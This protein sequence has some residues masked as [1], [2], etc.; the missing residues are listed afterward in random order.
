MSDPTDFGGE[1]VCLEHAIRGAFQTYRG[2]RF[3]AGVEALVEQLL[4]REPIHY[5]LP[6]E[7]EGIT[8]RFKVGEH[9]G[10]IT[11]STY[12]ANYP[13]AFLRGR[14]GEIF[15]V[16]AKEGSTISGLL[17]SFAISI[18]IQLQRGVTLQTLV[19]KFA[20]TRFEPAGF[21]DNPAIPQAT[22]IAD[23]IFRWLEKKFLK[24]EVVPEL[25]PSMGELSGNGS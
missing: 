5:H 25:P 17:D 10:Y 13:I 15:I 4:Q 11:V 6:P 9:K 16:M 14:L 8:H 21:T 23:Y 24:G 7:R 22:S 12:P 19:A 1:R 3:N 2:N 20:H 18:S